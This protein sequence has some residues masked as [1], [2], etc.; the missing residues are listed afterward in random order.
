MDDSKAMESPS[1]KGM[2]MAIPSAQAEVDAELAKLPPADV[3]HT[4]LD[5]HQGPRYDE[6]TD[7]LPV[8]KTQNYRSMTKYREGLA[9]AR[10][11][12]REFIRTNPVIQKHLAEELQQK[13]SSIRAKQAAKVA[14]VAAVSMAA[15][16]RAL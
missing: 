9:E 3:P 8:E 7:P 5:E 11:R 14:V 4:D 6:S 13:C 1:C 16:R 12:R 10:R 15:K 2:P